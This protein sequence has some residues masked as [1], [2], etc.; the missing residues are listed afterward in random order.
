MATMSIND[1]VFG[2]L[3]KPQMERHDWIVQVSLQSSVGLNQ[4]VLHDVTNID[5]TLDFLIESH[6]NQLAQRIAMLIHQLVDCGLVASLC[7]VEKRFR[8]IGC[9]PH[10]NI[11]AE[12]LA[13]DYR[14][15]TIIPDE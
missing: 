3:P 9:W 8:L 14:S 6:A 15:S 1:P 5:S 4:Y 11:V 13:S 12:T 2:D 10:L 7:L